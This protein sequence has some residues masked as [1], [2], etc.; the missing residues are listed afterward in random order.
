MSFL[1]DI[2]DDAIAN[3]CCIPIYKFQICQRNFGSSLESVSCGLRYFCEKKLRAS[4]AQI[5]EDLKQI[6]ACQTASTSTPQT[7]CPPFNMFSAMENP[8]DPKPNKTTFNKTSFRKNNLTAQRTSH[9][10]TLSH[11]NAAQDFEERTMVG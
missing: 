8:I 4:D 10:C 5:I 7:L 9:V 11:V 2:S 3:P 6:I 1:I